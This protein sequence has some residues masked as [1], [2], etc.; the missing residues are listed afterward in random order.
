MLTKI[1]KGYSKANVNLQKDSLGRL[2]VDKENGGPQRTS[3]HMIRPTKACW[4]KPLTQS[5]RKLV[6]QALAV[7]KDD[8][9]A[10]VG[11]TVIKQKDFTTLTELSEVKGNVLNSCFCVLQQIGLSQ[12]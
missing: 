1:Q 11:S 12:V 10:Y 3:L 6:T 8:E 4:S 2:V 5:Q 7:S 9:V